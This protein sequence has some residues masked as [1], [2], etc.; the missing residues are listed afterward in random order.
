MEKE[1]LKIKLATA[2]QQS[3]YDTPTLAK[4]LG[5]SQ[6]LLESYARGEKLPSIVVFANICKILNLDANKIM[7]S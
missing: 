2:I 7:K 4:Q 3:Q 5:I 1:T 6:K